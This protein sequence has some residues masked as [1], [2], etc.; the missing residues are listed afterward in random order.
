MRSIRCWIGRRF[1][2]FAWK[3]GIQKGPGEPVVIHDHGIIRWKLVEPKLFKEKNNDRNWDPE[4]YL[5]GNVY[6]G[7]HANPIG[8]DRD[9]IEEIAKEEEDPEDPRFLY[10][11]TLYR[12]KM[13]EVSIESVYSTGLRKLVKIVLAA[14]LAIGI[15][16]GAAIFLLMDLGAA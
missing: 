3:I 16:I 4:L 2:S 7:D 6:Y 9:K 5:Q 13:E 12:S 10:P 11:S 1:L 15:L 8:I 14:L